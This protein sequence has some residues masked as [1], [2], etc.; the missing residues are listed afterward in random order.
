MAGGHRPFMPPDLVEPVL[1]LGGD[2]D[3]VA[4]LTQPDRLSL[5]PGRDRVAH[6]LPADRPVVLAHQPLLTQ[7]RGERLVRKRMDKGQLIFEHLG[8]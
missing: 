6:L 5:E 4:V 8:R 7:R 1:G 3:V 2:D